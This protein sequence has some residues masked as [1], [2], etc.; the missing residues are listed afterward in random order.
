MASRTDDLATV[1]ARV[2]SHATATMS[3]ASVLLDRSLN[4]LYIDVRERGEVAGIPVVRLSEKSIRVP[5]RPLLR[6][7]GLDDE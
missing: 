5:S 7:V 3:D 4:R 2:K 1:V 6:L